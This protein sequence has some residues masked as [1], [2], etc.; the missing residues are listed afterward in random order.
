MSK[1]SF[2]QFVIVAFGVSISSLALA[3]NP[4]ALV[5]QQQAAANAEQASGGYRDINTRFGTVAA[6]SPQVLR[7]AGGYR[8]IHYRFQSGELRA[9]HT[10]SASVPSRWR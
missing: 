1:H 5:K 10:A 9:A 6:R 4:P 8:D 3:R 2:R 7:S